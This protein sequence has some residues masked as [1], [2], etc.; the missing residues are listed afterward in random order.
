V[1]ALPD[2]LSRPGTIY[3][4]ARLTGSGSDG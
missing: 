1:A 4:V 2:S 3:A